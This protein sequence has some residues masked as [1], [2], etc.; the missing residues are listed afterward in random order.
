MSVKPSTP[1]GCGIETPEISSQESLVNSNKETSESTSTI[2]SQISGVQDDIVSDALEK[3]YRNKNFVLPEKR[4]W[5]TISENPR[6]SR[7]FIGKSIQ[8]VVDF[9]SFSAIQSKDKKRHLKALKF[10]RGKPKFKPIPDNR[11]RKIMA[12]ID[13]DLSED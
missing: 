3:L 5:E 4:T 9:E 10:M 2:D 11:F 12:D 8:R 13:K 7:F 1:K 6:G